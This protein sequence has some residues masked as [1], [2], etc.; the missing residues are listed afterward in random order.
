MNKALSK[1]SAIPL[2]YQLKM[3]LLEQIDAGQFTP[4][5]QIPTEHEL[6]HQ[7]DLSRGTVRQALKELIDEGR[8]YPVRG[9]GTFIAEPPNET[10][11]FAT[12]ASI[13]EALDHKGIPYETPVL[14]VSSKKADALVA[15]NLLI[16][17]E[18]PV[19]F[20]KRLRIVEGRPLVI[21]E[22]YLPESIAA[23]LHKIDLTNCAFYRTLEEHCGVRVV[24]M[25]RTIGVRLA[26]EEEAHL[27][28]VPP[29]SAVQVFEE[30]A[31]DRAGKPVE[32]SYSV[33]RGDRSHL[34]LRITRL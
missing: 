25:D 19:V 5:E 34:Q 12:T 13:S 20:I 8:L 1:N 6:C 15:S 4:G 32:F 18:Q 16:E 30:L 26:T 29:G 9:R 31:Y 27:L 23:P 14:E 22:L 17:P 28:D 24:A 7:F 2:Y 11:S 21:Y 3:W 10:W 33:F